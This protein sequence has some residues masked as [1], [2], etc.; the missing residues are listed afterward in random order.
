MHESF[1]PRVFFFKKS[2]GKN[3]GSLNLI[4]NVG[5][6]EKI[7]LEGYWYILLKSSQSSNSTQTGTAFSG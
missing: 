4:K 1:P 3:L 6:N 5:Q 2:M 7:V